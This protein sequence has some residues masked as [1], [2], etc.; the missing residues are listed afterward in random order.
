VEFN[1]DGNGNLTAHFFEIIYDVT[2]DVSP[3]NVAQIKVG[4]EILNEL[5]QTLALQGNTAIQITTT[6]LQ[7]FYQFSH[8]TTLSAIASPDASIA[9]VSMTFQGPDVVIAHYVELP[10]YPLIIDTEP[11]NTGW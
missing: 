10:N 1:L 6:P 11:R 8:W 3:P 7:E 9:N 2:F 5:A 4:D